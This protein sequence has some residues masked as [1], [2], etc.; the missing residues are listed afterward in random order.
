MDQVNIFDIC[1][2]YSC[3]RAVFITLNNITW[4]IYAIC[5]CPLARGYPGYPCNW[6]SWFYYSLQW[7]KMYA[8][9]KSGRKNLRDWDFIWWYW[10]GLREQSFTLDQMLPGSR[11]NFVYLNRTYLE[12]GKSRMRPH[13]TWKRSSSHLY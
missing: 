7:G 9:S 12:G 5:Q 11:A 13:Y 2:F 8:L 4:M 1:S 10:K 3:M 6:T